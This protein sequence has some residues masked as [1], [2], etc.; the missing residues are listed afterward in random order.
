[1]QTL[2]VPARTDTNPGGEDL[3]PD[4]RGQSGSRYRD[5]SATEDPRRMPNS[6]S[7]ATP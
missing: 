3:F 6:V 1:M 5:P 2:D 7:P 4:G